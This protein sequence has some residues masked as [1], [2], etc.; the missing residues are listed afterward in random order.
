MVD[1]NDGQVLYILKRV[2]CNCLV[3]IAVMTPNVE[4]F[5]MQVSSRFL[6]EEE[7]GIDDVQSLGALGPEDLKEEL[8]PASL[9]HYRQPA[10][11]F[12][13]RSLVQF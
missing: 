7:G 13:G 12:R 1:L 11:R 5:Q 9:P 10:V 6:A 8:F 4:R 3:T 2:T